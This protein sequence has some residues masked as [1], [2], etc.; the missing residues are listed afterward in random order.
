MGLNPLLPDRY[1]NSYHRKLVL[2]GFKG[3][4]PY[5]VEWK[6]WQRVPQ[7]KWTGDLERSR[8]ENQTTS[9]LLEWKIS[10]KYR[11]QYRCDFIPFRAPSVCLL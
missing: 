6:R 1:S 11:K 2:W 8:A 9:Q 7:W 4:H 10:M 5:R 3:A